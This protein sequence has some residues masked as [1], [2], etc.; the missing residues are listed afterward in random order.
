MMTVNR[1]T[2]SHPERGILIKDFY[3]DSEISTDERVYFTF[4]G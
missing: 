3:T 1:D 2:K 4:F